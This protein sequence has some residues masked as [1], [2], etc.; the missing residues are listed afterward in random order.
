ME[1]NPYYPLPTTTN[2]RPIKGV[3]IEVSRLCLRDIGFPFNY[4]LGSIMLVSVSH[5]GARHT[6]ALP[7]STSSKEQPRD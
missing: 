5:K 2:K 6:P 3:D 4:P 1:L 7:C